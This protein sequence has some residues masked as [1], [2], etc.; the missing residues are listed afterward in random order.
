MASRLSYFLWSSLP[1]EELL[2]L[3]QRGELQKPDVLRAQVERMLADPKSNRFVESFTG[4]WLRLYDIDFTVPDQNLYPEYDQLLRQSM[5]DET[6]AFFREILDRD[7][8]VNNFIDSDFVMINEPLAHF[9]GIDGVEGLAIRRVEL[10]RDSVR[11]GVLDAGQCAQG[12]RGWH[13]NFAGPAR[14]V[15]SEVPVRHTVAATAADHR[16]D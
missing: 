13:E 14:R 1:D 7:H 11:G 8:S 9:Y 15:D 16:G 5:L 4:Q 3:A 12:L 10:P 6:H 2:A